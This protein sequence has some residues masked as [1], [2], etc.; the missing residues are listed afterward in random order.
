MGKGHLRLT[1]CTLS[2][3]PTPGKPWGMMGGVGWY[4]DTEHANEYGP[5]LGKCCAL[6]L[7]IREEGHLNGHNQ[8]R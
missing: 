4:Q 2:S 1:L 3:S 5:W 7:G 8:G 6:Q